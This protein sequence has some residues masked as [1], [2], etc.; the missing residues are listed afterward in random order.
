MTGVTKQNKCHKA[1]K[2]WQKVTSVWKGDRSE[3]TWNVWQKLT[4]CEKNL[5]V[6]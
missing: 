2:V 5:E 1:W 4:K 6:W 3:K